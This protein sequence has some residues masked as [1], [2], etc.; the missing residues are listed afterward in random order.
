M[1]NAASS[2]SGAPAQPPPPKA[3][4][5]AAAAAG[6]AATAALVHGTGALVHGAG[7]PR[8]AEQA[9]VQ[10]KAAAKAQALVDARRAHFK[11]ESQ[12]RRDAAQ[13]EARL[14]AA[15]SVPAGGGDT[16]RSIAA[17]SRGSGKSVHFTPTHGAQIPGGGS[18]DRSRS[19]RGARSV[20]RAPSGSTGH[21]SGNTDITGDIVSSRGSSSRRYGFHMGSSSGESS[22][23]S[24][25]GRTAAAA[26]AMAGLAGGTAQGTA[27]SRPG[28]GAGGSTKD[29]GPIGT[30]SSGSRGY[31][32]APPP[33][34]GA[35]AKAKAKA[36]TIASTAGSSTSPPAQTT[37]P[38][39]T[40]SNPTTPKSPAKKPKK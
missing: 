27:S 15:A 6:A 10:G 3:K 40:R 1:G 2:S 9:T 34:A 30:V 28:L 39:R 23:A 11:A 35:V 5:A 16:G 37:T 12:G 20:S 8:R 21:G 14:R 36:P 4:A 13:E 17:S 26:A 18:G 19:D 24:S 22:S 25:G 32:P 29:I 31:P 33:G 7:T 38:R